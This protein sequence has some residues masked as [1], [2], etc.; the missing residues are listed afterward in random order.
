MEEGSRFWRIQLV[1]KCVNA[2]TTTLLTWFFLEAAKQGFGPQT[3]PFKLALDSFEASGVAVQYWEYVFIAAIGAAAGIMG[4]V[5]VNVN[6]RLTKFRKRLNF[7]KPLQL[8]EVMFF[9]VLSKW[10]CF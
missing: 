10:N 2:T 5:F 9:T 3:I 4:G 1:W 8:L 7:S 6:I